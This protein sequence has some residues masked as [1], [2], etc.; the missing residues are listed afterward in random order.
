MTTFTV[1]V[2][3]QQVLDVLAKLTQRMGNL[4]PALQA[5]GD[6]M[7]ERTKQ[8][9]D[10]Q[11]APDGSAWKPLS[12]VTLGLFAGGLGK[13]YR[14]K[15][16]SLNKRGGQAVAGKRILIGES[17]D[18]SRQIFSKADAS[19]M[20]L[21]A[22]PVYAAMHQ[23]GG[24]T[25]ANSMIPGKRIPARPFMPVDSDGNLDPTEQRL[26]LEA[27]QEFLVGDF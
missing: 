4:Q 3:D 7:L 18:L 24:I 15:D 14:K 10:S 13:S 21:W 16:G 12:P 27:L 5:L 9:F 23:F 17:G 19:S 2:K 22:S 1:E 25:A 20:M 8:R 26:V 11:T 6:D